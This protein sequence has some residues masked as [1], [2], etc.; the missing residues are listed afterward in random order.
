MLLSF[1][2]NGKGQGKRYLLVWAFI[3]IFMTCFAALEMFK[4]DI[5]PY[6]NAKA[7]EL[8]DIAPIEIKNDQVVSP[9]N[10]LKTIRF[11]VQGTPVALTIDTRQDELNLAGVSTD[12]LSIVLTR[13][14]VYTIADKIEVKPIKDIHFKLTKQMID[15]GLIPE[16]AL[17]LLWDKAKPFV[18]GF[19]LLW[20]IMAFV[21][22]LIL[23]LLLG[24]M[25]GVLEGLVKAPK[26]NFSAQCR[27]ATLC[28]LIVGL[29]QLILKPLLPIA[30]ISVFIAYLLCETVFLCLLKDKA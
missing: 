24:L 15:N 19:Y 26:M 29:L 1:I 10:V 25:S 17:D 2:K 28:I 16:N 22:Y 7:K 27:L 14:F 6:V 21:G 30:G 20:S 18:I 9:V 13:K 5:I 4:T 11:D 12:E 3:S 23:M 8:S